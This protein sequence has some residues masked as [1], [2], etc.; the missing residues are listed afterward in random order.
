MIN[1]E[2]KKDK[3]SRER[4]RGVPEGAGGDSNFLT[5]AGGGGIFCF[6]F[7]PFEVLYLLFSF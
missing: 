7:C 2:L 4:K 1:R 3:F 6:Q 5:R